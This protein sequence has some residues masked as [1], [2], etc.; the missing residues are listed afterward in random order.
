MSSL[1]L[2]AAPVG[3]R[4]TLSSLR[5][6]MTL[7]FTAFFA[8]FTLLACAC[9]HQ[10][11]T[12]VALQDMEE[13]TRAAARLVAQEWAGDVSPEGIQLAF[14]EAR[15][16]ARLYNVS[17]IMVD[18]SGAVLGADRYP[19]L[20]WPNPQQQGWLVVRQKI[21]SVT[22]VAGMDWNKKEYWLR[23]QLAV[24][25]CFALLMT[26]AA[27]AA[28][29]I[30]VGRTL[31]PIGAL[32]EQADTAS[33]DPLHVHLSP[34]SEDAEVQRLVETL[35]RFLNRLQENTRTREQFYAAAA[36]ELRTP[37]AVLSGSVEVAL[38]RPREGAEYKETLSEL[39]QQ[40]RRLTTLVEDLLTLNRLEMN[41]ESDE[42]KETI[43]I[44]TLCSRPLKQLA[45]V[46][47][48][49]GLTVET[50]LEAAVPVLASAGYTAILARNVLENAVKYATPG[51][52]VSVA[53]HPGNEGVEL[54]VYNDY[55]T[56]EK[57]DLERLFEP[58]YR[59]DSSRS[60]ATGG[61][62]L[63]LAICRR[64]AQV[65]GW[66]LTLQREPGGI[67]LTITLPATN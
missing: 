53:A 38:S 46:I 45:S 56:P 52:R 54:H 33:A 66:P 9:F 37:L 65:N 40:I 60:S 55:P 61:N 43:D 24:L 64:I 42:A 62:G 15:Q 13:R 47:A 16:D 28:T 11:A 59:A 6:R 67:G 57:L 49:R 23:R 50:D 39:Q 25:L 18:A 29:W 58:F 2:A 31:R 51:G 30:L 26:G 5:A 35:N 1:L 19:S 21:A 8:V 20:P 14:E 22:I 41:A 17:L 63:G 12:H 32:S 3:A 27:G 48:E 44:P 10:W 7:G 4:F 34:P 36:H